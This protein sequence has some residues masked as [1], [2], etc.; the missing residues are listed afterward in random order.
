[1]YIWWCLSCQIRVWSDVPENRWMC[2][3]DVFPVAL[4]PR[5]AWVNCRSTSMQSSY[6]AGSQVVLSVP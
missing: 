1:V 4:G 3:F 6:V 5:F 2:A